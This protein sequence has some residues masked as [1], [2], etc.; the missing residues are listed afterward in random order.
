[1]RYLAVSVDVN[2]GIF[3]IMG[4]KHVKKRS[5]LISQLKERLVPA[6][7]EKGFEVIPLLPYEQSSREIRNAFPLGRLRRLK[8]K[9]F[10]LVEIQLDKRGSPKFRINFGTVPPEGIDHPIQHVKQS[11]A[12]V[13]YLSYFGEL[14]SWPAFLKWFSVDSAWLSFNPELKARSVVERVVSLIVE[15]EA[16]FESGK[17]GPHVR[18]VNRKPA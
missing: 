3:G 5:L 10:E 17:I 15:I 16:W 13:H 11:D 6:F 7:L 9:N 4:S 12:S 1:M 18:N 2:N 14:Y 8:G